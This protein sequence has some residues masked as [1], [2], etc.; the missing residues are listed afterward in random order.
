[1]TTQTAPPSTTSTVPAVAQEAIEELHR[2]LDQI[3]WPRRSVGAAVPGF[4]TDRLR[5]LVERWRHGFDWRALEARLEALGQFMTTTA[6]GRRLHALHSRGGEALPILLVHGWPDSPLR[7]LDLIPLLNAAGRDVVA[8]SIPG[9]GL[10][11]EPVGEISRDLVAEDFHAL[12]TE[13]GY[14]R[15]A[16]HGGDW[17][18]AIGTALARLHPEAVAAL[19]LSD[20]PFDLAFT[21]DEASATEAEV[22]YLRSIERSA[23]GE[24]YQAGNISQPD[25]TALALSDSPV[26]LLGWLAHL[27]DQWSEEEIDPDHLLANASLL[28]LTGT[29][30]SSMRLY[31]EP[32]GAWDTS[33]WEDADARDW[34]G[35]DAEG[36]QTTGWGESAS[37]AP[38]RLEVPTAFALFPQDLAMAPRALA[39]RHFAVER[40]TVMP[41]GG[42]FAALEQPDLLAE[43]LTAFLDR[44][45]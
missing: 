6:D 35:Q 27:Y 11:E 37:W 5:P 28:W 29:V 30:R 14:S 40:F 42:H 45:S 23:G 2:R 12:M 17:G 7:F 34:G 31:C 16:V 3:V 4:D 21:I 15:Y 43:D 44:R 1:M 39:E 38:E 9:F 18:S 22:A 19:H 13:L 36:A 33:A 26:G 24:L 25:V 41:R 8:P 20:V 32:A 10:S